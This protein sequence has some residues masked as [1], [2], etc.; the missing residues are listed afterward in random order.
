MFFNN[1]EDRHMSF[2]SLNP[3]LSAALAANW[4][5]NFAEA[6]DAGN[7]A[8]DHAHYLCTADKTVWYKVNAAVKYA[9]ATADAVL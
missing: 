1:W 6:L 4:V 3:R 8:L 9:E 7:G 2:L 5:Q